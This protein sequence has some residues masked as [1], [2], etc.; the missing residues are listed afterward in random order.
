MFSLYLLSGDVQRS[1]SDN[2]IK[3]HRMLSWMWISTGLKTTS[4]FALHVGHSHQNYKRRSRISAATLNWVF[5]NELPTFVTALGIKRYQNHIAWEI[6]PRPDTEKLCSCYLLYFIRNNFILNCA[7]LVHV[8]A[9]HLILPMLAYIL[10]SVV[11]V[12]EISPASE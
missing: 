8:Y 10:L 11:L 3:N 12:V 2:G 7:Y 5:I 6:R 4:I 1:K 9:P